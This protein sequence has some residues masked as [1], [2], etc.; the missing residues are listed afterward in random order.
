MIALLFHSL[1]H[2]LLLFLPSQKADDIEI[3]TRGGCHWWL[4]GSMK[5]V[6]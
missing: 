2:R 6:S 4:A 5:A 3:K 1:S